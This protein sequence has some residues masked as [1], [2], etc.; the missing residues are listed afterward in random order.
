LSTVFGNLEIRQT[1]IV[2]GFGLGGLLGLF[3]LYGYHPKLLII[4]YRVKLNRPLSRRLSSS[5]A[6]TEPSGI[7]LA[8]YQEYLCATYA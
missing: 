6:L 1:Q 3:D 4:R 8:S 5:G 2:S 7:W